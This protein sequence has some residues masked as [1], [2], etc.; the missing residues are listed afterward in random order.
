MADKTDEI[1]EAKQPDKTSNRKG[2]N[3]AALGI[4]FSTLAIVIF[5]CAF[6]VWL[7]STGESEHVTGSHGVWPG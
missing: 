6:W 7:F 1:T 3:W 2:I 4:F 5:V